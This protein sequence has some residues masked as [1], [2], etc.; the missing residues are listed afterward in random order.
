[1]QDDP[2]ADVVSR[3]YERWRYPQPITDLTQMPD[4]IWHWYDPTHFH[5]IL[6]PDRE[7]KPDLDI[8]IAGCG[9]NQAAVFA[10]KNPGA[11]VV[12]VDISR[13]SLDHQ[14]YLKD[15]HGLW[16]LELHLL[17]I[18]ELGSLGLDF[19]LIVSTG[20]LHHLADPLV[21]MKTLGA[22]LRSDGAIGL[23][24]YAKYGR[25]GVEMLQPVFR[26]LGLRQDEVS[27]QIV[28]EMMALLPADHHIQSYLRIEG[29]ELRYDGAVVDT[30]LHGRDR[31]YDVDECIDLVTAAGLVFQGWLLNAPYYPHDS[32][33]P[34]TELNRAVNA[35]PERQLWS[36]MERVHTFGACHFFM[37]CRPER[38][39][40]TYT[41]DFSTRDCLDYVP[42]FRMR[43]GLSGNEIFRTDWRM[44]LNAA[45]LPFAQRVD[46]RRT[47]RD[48]AGS[49][50]QAGASPRAS[51]ADVETFA[52]K[53]FQSLWRLDFLAMGLPAQPAGPSG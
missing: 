5:R 9:T 45:Q 47:I 43:C 8:L 39:K 35:L 15:K 1:M 49:V 33:A 4:G 51:S 48:I 14:Q 10:Y 3:Q 28:K 31:S 53:L 52:R 27:V 16:N 6:W 38:P 46:G 17:P 12:G 26:D 32:F 37:A 18:E 36:I 42:M 19:D 2:R 21:G 24:L 7:Y 40:A 41:I 23:T 11:K 29:S 34:G 50:A 20:V 25:V 22:C 30:F 13:P 44:A